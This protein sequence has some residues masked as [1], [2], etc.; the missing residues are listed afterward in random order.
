MHDLLGM[1]V[2]D[3]LGDLGEDEPDISLGHQH[4]VGQSAVLSLAEGRNKVICNEMTNIIDVL[5]VPSAKNGG[6]NVQKEE[7]V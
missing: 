3:S 5:L 2:G 7:R 6:K 1:G 4:L